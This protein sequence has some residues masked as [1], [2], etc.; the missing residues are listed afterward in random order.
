M[1]P[2]T[3]REAS[4]GAPALPFVVVDVPRSPPPADKPP[5]PD[6]L[7]AARMAVENACVAHLGAGCRA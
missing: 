1:V 5:S 4:P 7:M 3:P 2:W 6:E